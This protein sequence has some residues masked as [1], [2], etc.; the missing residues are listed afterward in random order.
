[1]GYSRSTLIRGPQSY[2]G[3]AVSRVYTCLP[4]AHSHHADL[5]TTSRYLATTRVG[6]QQARR[7]FEQHRAG[8]ARDSHKTT[9]DAAS[10]VPSASPETPAN[11][12]N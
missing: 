9:S 5:A 10:N 8:F 1:M 4:N 2:L 6:L 3:R 12:L 7:V 11:L